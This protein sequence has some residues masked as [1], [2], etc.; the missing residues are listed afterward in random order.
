MSIGC[1]SGGSFKRFLGVAGGGWRLAGA[2]KYTKW[3]LKYIDARLMV[4]F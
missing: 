1:R 2:R 3:T 4:Q